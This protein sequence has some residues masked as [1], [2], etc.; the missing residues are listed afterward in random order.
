MMMISGSKEVTASGETTP[1]G[2]AAWPG[3]LQA[4]WEN[5]WGSGYQGLVSL[6]SKG[7][8]MVTGMYKHVP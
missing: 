2:W 5:T 7:K 6:I 8:R 3:E 1:E 4:S